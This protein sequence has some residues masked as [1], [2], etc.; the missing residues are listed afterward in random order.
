MAFVVDSSV[1]VA[2]CVGSQATAVSRRLS[3]RAEREA[4]HAPALWPFEFV[5]ALWS[6]ER[7]RSLRAHQVDGAI[8]RA[9][10][11]G[12]TVHGEPVVLRELLDLARRLELAVYD[13]SY[14]ALAQRLGLP[15]ASLDTD[16]LA[17]ARRIGIATL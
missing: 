5:N 11:I 1:T 14:L 12:I 4:V 3:N 2:W 6:L 9:E 7:R 17:A 16:Q 15:L 10:R 13:V 8:S